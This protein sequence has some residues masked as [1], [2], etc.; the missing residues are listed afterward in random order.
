MQYVVFLLALVLS[1]SDDPMSLRRAWCCSAR[2]RH[3]VAV[4]FD[5]ALQGVGDGGLDSLPHQAALH[6]NG[7]DVVVHKHAGCPS[8]GYGALRFGKRGLAR[9]GRNLSIHKVLLSGLFKRHVAA[10]HV[11]SVWEGSQFHRSRRRPRL[12]DRIVQCKKRDRRL[13]VTVSGPM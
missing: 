6:E 12:G 11:H 1:N 4:N 9:F 2:C 8:G 10:G 3:P 7:P 13:N 5:A